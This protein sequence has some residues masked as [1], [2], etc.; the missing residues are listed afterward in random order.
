[1]FIE[2]VFAQTAQTGT[3]T[4]LG[5]IGGQGLGTL[6]N[7]P[8]GTGAQG[9]TDALTKLTNVIS[10]VIGF[11]TVC[12]AIWFIFMFLIGGYTWMTSMGDKHRLEE[13]RDRIVDALIG[14]VIVVAAWG[15]LALVGHFLGI[16]SVISQ[17]GTM[18]NSLLF[19]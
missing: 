9:G 3:G 12:A 19:K 10:A 13:A 15:I 16:D 2:K 8:F 4:S 5:T 7:I 6:G 1:M 18:I 17:P 11:M 14:L